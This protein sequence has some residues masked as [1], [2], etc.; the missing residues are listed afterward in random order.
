MHFEKL[1][2]LFVSFGRVGMVG[3]G[4]GPSMIPLVEY[5]VVNH[6]GWMTSEE[7]NQILAVGN[8]LPG[9][10]ATKMAGYVGY[11]VAGWS[12]ALAALF[13]VMGPTVL[14]MIGLYSVLQRF[15]DSP[16]ITGITRGITPVVIVLLALLVYDTARV[17]F[18][19]GGVHPAVN[20][21]MIVV[22]FFMLQ[23]LPPA[24]VVAIAIVFGAVFLRG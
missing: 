22:S 8:A 9:P 24:A 5:E 21:A 6:F 1:W 12:G 3:Y 17:A 4:G 18:R 20:V 2:Q 7:F 15:K 23:K 14:V 16:A 13:G 10:I 19:T 11:K